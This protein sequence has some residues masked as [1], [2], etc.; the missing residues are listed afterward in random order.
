MHDRSPIGLTEQRDLRSGTTNWEGGTENAPSSDPL[1]GEL[2]DVAIIGAGIMGAVLAERLSADGHSVVLL[3][4]REPGSG[5]TAAST[6][7]LMWAMDVPLCE[8]ADKIG[9]GEAARRWRRVYQAVCNLAARI[10]ELGIDCA[11]LDRPTIYFAGD[12]LDEQG[13]RRE[14]EMHQA[15][16][17]PSL[18]LDAQATAHRFGIA[19]RAS[20]VSDGGFE[21]DPVMLAHGLL[22][23]ARGRGGALCFPHDVTSIGETADGVALS[24]D[25]GREITARQV[26]LAGGYER[27]SLF[28]PADFTLLSTYVMATPPGTAPLWREG[29]MIWE[30]SDPYLYLR[31]DAAGRIIVGGEDE[32]FAGAEPRD[33]LIG[34]KA[35]TIAAKAGALIGG[36]PLT[37][38][39]AWAA[40]F[41]ASP[42]GLPAIGPAANMHNVWLS[43]GFGGNGIAFAGL[44]S[45]LLSA[46]LGGRSDPD[47]ECFDPYRFS[48]P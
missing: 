39:R 21:V 4:R 24:L 44:A 16:R 6:A 30:A 29:A 46:A 15:H 13:L 42:D 36:E 20:I 37:I 11:R 48:L 9:A 18:Y 25:G 35:G 33:A 28:L 2:R 31:A 12:S 41:G 19:P 40:T 3:D 22:E 1:P 34:E 27:A 7:Q 23:I 10:D 8:L 38:D 14:A 47:A 17:L 43:A 5:S 45:E 32:H 26:I